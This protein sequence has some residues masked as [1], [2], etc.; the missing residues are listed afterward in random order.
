MGTRRQWGAIRELPSGRFQ[1]RYPN[2]DSGTTV[3][4]PHTFANRK[5][6]DRWLAKKRTEIDAGTA[7]DDKLAQRPLKHVA[8]GDAKL[9]D[10]AVRSWG[11]EPVKHGP[12][13]GQ[14]VF[15]FGHLRRVLAAYRLPDLFNA[16]HPA[17]RGCLCAIRQRWGWLVA[18]HR[19]YRDDRG[20]RAPSIGD[21]GDLA[22]DR[23]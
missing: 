2:M 21:H 13:G 3:A 11:P 9:I 17:G 16:A 5:A 1:A 8:V 14:R 18:V 4:A 23:G 20:Y 6:V 12:D 22:G 7:G 19:F 10:G 15:Q